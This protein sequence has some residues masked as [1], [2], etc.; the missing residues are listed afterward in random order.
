MKIPINTN[1]YFYLI[2]HMCSIYN[3]KLNISQC[4]IFLQATAVL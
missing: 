3:N 1:I 2:K 4:D